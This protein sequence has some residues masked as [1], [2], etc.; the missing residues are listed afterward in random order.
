MDLG[1]LAKLDK[2][3]WPLG[4]SVG[5]HLWVATAQL[6]YQS[7]LLLLNESAFRKVTFLWGLLAYTI[8][9]QLNS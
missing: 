4:G 1:G 2:D 6:L 7:K 3:L 9:E 8:L 5:C